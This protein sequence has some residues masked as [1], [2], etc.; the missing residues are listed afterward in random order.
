VNSEARL[1]RCAFRSVRPMAD[2][3]RPLLVPSLRSPKVPPMERR[4]RP[5]Y[6][7][8]P[9]RGILVFESH[10]SSTFSMPPER[11]TF[12]KLCWVPVGHGSLE[13]GQSRITLARDELI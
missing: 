2:D 3:G 12:H 10:H 13:Y 8:L 5:A 6:H 7:Q 9:E 4:S 1:R 11:R